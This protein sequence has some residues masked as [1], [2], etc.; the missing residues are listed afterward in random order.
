MCPREGVRLVWEFEPG[1]W[2]NK[3]SE[4][5]RTVEADRVIDMLE[6][7]FPDAL[8]ALCQMPG[9]DRENLS[10]RQNNCIACCHDIGRRTADAGIASAFHPNSPEGSIFRTRKDYDLLL[11][12]LNADI[13]GFAPD[14][15]HIAKGDMDPVEIF[16]EY[17]SA[18]R[19]VHFKDMTA[20]GTWAEMGKGDI[21][22]AGIVRVLTDNGYNCWIM[23]EDE[24]ARAEDD[25]DGVTMDNGRYVQSKFL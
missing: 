8:L 19:H 5:L 4:V 21:D 18:I 24:S 6:A 13:I 22:F 15:G 12:Q 2:L 23:I 16:R 20:S 11:D 10:E 1:F 7:H 25:P 3:P 9:A 14:C 17:A